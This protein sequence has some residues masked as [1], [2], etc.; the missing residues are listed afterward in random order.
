MKPR[1]PLCLFFAGVLVGSISGH[2]KEIVS[3]AVDQ[4]F[5]FHGTCVFL[6]SAFLSIGLFLSLYGLFS[7]SVSSRKFI[8]PCLCNLSVIVLALSIY[9]SGYARM[10][11]M[12]QTAYSLDDRHDVLPKLIE[13]IKTVDT[14]KEKTTI[15]GGAYELYGVKIAYGR[16]NG[17]ISYY[18]PTDNEVSSRKQFEKGNEA[19]DEIK[20]SVLSGIQKNLSYV[21]HFFAI[22]L[23]TFFL[24]FL[25]GTVWVALK[26]STLR[27]EIQP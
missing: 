25:I 3:A 7:R 22:Y 10:T 20:A 11:K 8:W 24:T 9:F 23:G 2:G 4:S 15:A 16:Q 21:S 27:L 17:Q 13:K 1:H 26:S 12:L 5:V 19:T 6:S 14:D 18:E